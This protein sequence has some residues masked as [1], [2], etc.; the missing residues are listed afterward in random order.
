MLLLASIIESQCVYYFCI[1]F[2][3]LF[4]FRGCTITSQDIKSTRFKKGAKNIILHTWLHLVHLTR[5]YL[6][7]MV[8]KDK[9][10]IGAHFRSEDYHPNNVTKHNMGCQSK[11]RVHTASAVSGGRHDHKSIRGLGSTQ[12][13]SVHCKSYCLTPANYQRY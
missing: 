4:F 11:D 10:V 7:I 5:M 12:T 2:I 13:G 8:V 9:V 1:K 3:Y 6:T